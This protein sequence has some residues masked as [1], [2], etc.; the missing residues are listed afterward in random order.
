MLPIQKSVTHFISFRGELK[1]K[2]AVRYR[3]QRHCASLGL[4]CLRMAH[5]LPSLSASSQ[6]S[7]TH[8][9]TKDQR[10][11]ARVE[12][13]LRA[14]MEAISAPLSPS[15]ISGSSNELAHSG[16]ASAQASSTASLF[17]TEQEFTRFS[18]SVEALRERC[19]PWQQHMQGIVHSV[20][21]R[22]KLAAASAQQTSPVL[23]RTVTFLT[24]EPQSAGKTKSHQSVASSLTT[25]SP[26]A[27][28]SST[29]SSVVSTVMS[30]SPSSPVAM[31][32]NDMDIAA[33]AAGVPVTRP[34]R[35]SSLS[36]EEH[37]AFL[38]YQQIVR[39]IT[40]C[41]GEGGN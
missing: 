40:D 15:L 9:I 11:Q 29:A 6:E 27:P 37:A 13:K 38:Q 12:S 25:T 7:L 20:Q 23:A 34:T 31:P 2:Q 24:P 28:P 10:L 1:E 18:R 33:Q 3:G 35:F 21:E 5:S 32:R 4:S 39:S 8:D 19:A 17:F 36:Q 26:A 14:S 16:D 41:I 30:A 22:R